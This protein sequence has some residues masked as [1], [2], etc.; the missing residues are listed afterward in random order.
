MHSVRR[1]SLPDDLASTLAEWQND[2][3]AV[4]N[5]EEDSKAK[6][7]KIGKYWKLKDKNLLK[8]ELLKTYKECCCYCESKITPSEF[9][10]IE[11][12][13]PKSRFPDRTFIID[14]LHL[15]CTKCNTSKLDKYDLDNEVLDACIDEVEQHL[16]ISSDFPGMIMAKNPRGSTTISYCT[17][18]RDELLEA[19]KQAQE[20]G[21]NLLRNM[22]ESG[23]DSSINTRNRNLLEIR[24]TH[25]QG[26]CSVYRNIIENDDVLSMEIDRTHWTM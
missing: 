17:L 12:R 21:L 11:H 19:I 18:N 24:A 6:T 10:H 20:V 22:L 9:G 1:P 8:D 15:S 5:Q 16:Q 25:G 7:Q 14:N 13:L 3:T 4:C 2:V 23:I 26:Y